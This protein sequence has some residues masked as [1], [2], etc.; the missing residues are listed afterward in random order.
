MHVMYGKSRPTIFAPEIVII[1]KM[2]KRFQNLMR[3]GAL[4]RNRKGKRVSFHDQLNRLSKEWATGEAGPS[5][6]RYLLENQSSHKLSDEEMAY[7]AGSL[8]SAS[9]YGCR[10]LLHAIP[11][12]RRK[13]KRN[14][15]PSLVVTGVG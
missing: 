15:T 13:C 4:L 2:F 11:R 7:L 5:F 14:W 8:F 6:S 10:H 9:N 3:P 1:H 12:C